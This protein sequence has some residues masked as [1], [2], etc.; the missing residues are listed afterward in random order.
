MADLRIPYVVENN[1]LGQRIAQMVAEFNTA[2]NSTLQIIRI[3]ACIGTVE[4]I[5]TALGM[6]HG[7]D[8]AFHLNGLL[9][10]QKTAMDSLASDIVK[11][12]KGL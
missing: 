12:D 7:A 8:Y 3:L 11:I 6:A 1:Y 5:E 10:T 2:Y 9:A 4:D